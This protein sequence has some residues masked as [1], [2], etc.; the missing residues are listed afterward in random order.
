MDVYSLHPHWLHDFTQCV[1]LL[2]FALDPFY[3]THVHQEG[4]RLIFREDLRV[5]WVSF[6]FVYQFKVGGAVR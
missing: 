6:Q 5:E 2:Q 4:G 3:R 1:S